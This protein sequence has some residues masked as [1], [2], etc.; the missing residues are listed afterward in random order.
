MTEAITRS[1]ARSLRRLRSLRG[2]KQSHLAELLGVSQGTVSRWE[3][4]RLTPGP[5]TAGAIARLLAP[6][7]GADAALRRLVEAATAPMHLICD[8][9]HVLLAASSARQAG[10]RVAAADLMGRSLWRYAS[11]EIASLEERLPEFLWDEGAQALAFRT[12]ANRDA[13][14]PIRPGLTLWE[15]LLLEDGRPARLVSTVAAPPPHARLVGA[16]A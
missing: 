7:P 1:A 14:V 10:W 11:D 13:D 9:T 12:G 4:G 16:R 15:R 2:M 6:R 8:A 3:T 5:E